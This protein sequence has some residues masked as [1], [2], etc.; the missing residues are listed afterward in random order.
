MA[1]HGDAGSA[2]RILSHLVHAGALP[3]IQAR[4][5][6][7]QIQSHLWGTSAVPMERSGM[8]ASAKFPSAEL[9]EQFF[10]ELYPELPGLL[11]LFALPSRQATY[12]QDLAGA[13]QAAA[14]A[15][16]AENVYFTVALFRGKP[17]AGRGDESLVLGIPGI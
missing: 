8:T 7:R 9:A 10:R 14:A 3:G 5:G 17:A 6:D 12:H 4:L 15:A 11:C 2:V 16:E 13:A 1:S